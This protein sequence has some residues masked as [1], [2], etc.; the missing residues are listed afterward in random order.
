MRYIQQIDRLDNNKSVF[1]LFN[2]QQLNRIIKM[3]DALRGCSIRHVVTT[4]EIWEKLKKSG[5]IWSA[6]APACI[7]AQ[8][9][10]LD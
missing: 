8:I 5:E 9:T 4:K 10:F 7:Y 6:F 3:P 2:E 1:L